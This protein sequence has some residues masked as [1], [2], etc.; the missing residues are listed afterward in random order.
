MR[1]PIELVQDF[2]DGELSPTAMAQLIERYGDQRAAAEREQAIQTAIG[3][4]NALND[5]TAA[6]DDGFYAGYKLAIRN[7]IAALRATAA[8]TT[9]A[10]G[11][12]LGFR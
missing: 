8:P 4:A 6:L 1:S 7:V 10:G 5:D 11:S 3:Q 2:L 12:A 9:D